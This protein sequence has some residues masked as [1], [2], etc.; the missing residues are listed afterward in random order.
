MSS[1][2]HFLGIDVG[3]GSARAG[4]FTEEGRLLASASRA[5]QMWKPAPDHV[6]QSSEDIWEACGVAARR[7]LADAKVSAESVVG[8]GFDAT[9]SLVLLDAQ[10]KP[11]SVS[12]TGEAQQNVIVW[13]DHRAILQAERINATKHPVLR[14]VG[15]VISPEMQT[16]KLLWLEGNMPQAWRATARFLDL[17][18]YLTYRATGG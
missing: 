7:A 8:V 4:V 1:P 9:C 18:D 17:P 16:P 12:V 3:T 6:E 5:I 13:M 15:G 2:K 14:Y 11:V 10:D